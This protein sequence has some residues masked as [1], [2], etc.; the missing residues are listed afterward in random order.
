MAEIA[1]QYLQNPGITR[2]GS[3]EFVSKRIVEIIEAKHSL[4]RN[5]VLKAYMYTCMYI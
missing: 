4:L 5:Y 2:K 1:V 3:S